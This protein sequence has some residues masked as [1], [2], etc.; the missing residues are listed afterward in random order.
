M[1]GSVG[2]QSPAGHC[3][4]LVGLVSG[5][6][7]GEGDR[8]LFVTVSL[9]REKKVGKGTV[10]YCTINLFLLSSSSQVLWNRHVRLS[11]TIER[12]IMIALE[13]II[14]ADKNLKYDSNP[15]SG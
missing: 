11:G 1:S 4:V 12:V 9:T 13:V 2:T 7:C 3:V 10:N 5:H 14:V 6:N 15:D 8:L